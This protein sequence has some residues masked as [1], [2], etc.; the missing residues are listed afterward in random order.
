MVTRS[1]LLEA[2]I[3][4]DEIRHRL[5]GG[6]LLR[7]H[8]SVY[9]VGHA[10]SWTEAQYLAA[11]LACGAGA[12][13]GGRASAHNYGIVRGQAPAVEVT[14][15]RERRVPG[16]TVLRAR[17]LDQRDVGVW[18]RIPT[19]TIARTLVEIAGG[20]T[21]SDLARACHEAGVR[22]RTTPGHVGQALGRWPNAPG[23]RRLRQVMAGDARVS[24]SRL[25]SAFLAL[26][27]ECR[28]PLPETNRPAGGRRVDCRWP[29]ARVTVE[30]DSY[31]FH[32]SRHAWERDH[33]REREAY[34][35]GDQFRRYTWADIFEDSTAMVG[36]LGP[37]LGA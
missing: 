34:A 8:P 7:V 29:E 3:T 14:C 16:I 22:Y 15:P 37:L 11:V 13:L 35:R 19:V 32:N 28:L 6:S 4:P 26:L 36:E 9:R 33:R 18:R 5:T 10:A 1:G 21:T 20:M 12:V 30:L 27:R 25:E 2:G 17:R 31:T 24:L 23:A